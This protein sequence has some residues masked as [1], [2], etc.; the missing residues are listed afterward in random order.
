MNTAPKVEGEILALKRFI[1]NKRRAVCIALCLIC[2]DSK[3]LHNPPNNKFWCENIFM[4]I[5]KKGK[6]QVSAKKFVPNKKGDA[7]MWVGS[8]P[9]SYVTDQ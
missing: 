7:G 1:K 9:K 8:H 5:L 2:I 3:F 6:K 4:E